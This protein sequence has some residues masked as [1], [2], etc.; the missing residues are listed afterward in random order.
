MRSVMPRTERLAIAKVRNAL[1]R[2]VPPSRRAPRTR[3][4][5]HYLGHARIGHSLGSGSLVDYWKSAP[6]LLNF[7]EEY[8]VKRAFRGRTESNTDPTVRQLLLESPSVLLSHA[9]LKRYRAVDPC[10]ARLRSLINDF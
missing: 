4:I 3:D 2:E 9:D 7:M 8:E 5:D 1:L 10:N 6:Y